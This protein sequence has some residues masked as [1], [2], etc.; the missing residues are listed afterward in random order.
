MAPFFD[1]SR[2]MIVPPQ[3]STQTMQ[4]NI[5]NP[6]SP[7]FNMFG[8]FSNFMQLYNQ[9]SASGVN[10]QMIVQQMFNSGRISQDQYNWAAQIANQ[11]TGRRF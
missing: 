6:Q 2:G 11:I 8:G 3:Q 5:V 9:I 4:P 7:I 1:N 10:P